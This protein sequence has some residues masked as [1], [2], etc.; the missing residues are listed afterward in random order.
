MS[1]SDKRQDAAIRSSLE[2]STLQSADSIVA[3]LQPWLDQQDLGKITAV[4][5]PGTSGAS[6]E[7]YVVDLARG[8]AMKGCVVRLISSRVAYPYVDAGQQYL[9]QKILAEGSVAPVPQPIAFEPDESILGAPFILMDYVEGNGASDWPSYVK[10]G[11]IYDLDADQR[12]RLW[13]NGLNAIVQIHRADISHAD[14]ARLALR[15]AGGTTLDRLVAY[16]RLYLDVVQTEGN[17]PVLEQAVTWLETAQPEMADD[18]T[19][20][21]GDA[22]LRNMLFRKLNPVAILDLEFAHLGVPA[23]DVAFFVMMDRVMAEAYAQT[24]RLDGFWDE[25]QTFDYYEKVTGRRIDHR[26]YF[27]RMAVTYMALANTRVF[28]RLA[29]EGKMPQADV[30]NNPPLIYL[31]GMFA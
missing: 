30:E 1:A 12:S 13:E 8:H 27:C 6:S 5:T 16:W 11:W 25:E 14:P 9:C 23:F 24:P 28:Q 21:W 7:I 31:K 26:Q 18:P 29:R 22:S 4:R 20:I 2:K 15:T 17:Y 3:R 10:E 19:M